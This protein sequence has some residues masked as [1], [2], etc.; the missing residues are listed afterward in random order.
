MAKAAGRESC[1]PEI[2]AIGWDRGFHARRP[3]RGQGR[4]SPSD[5]LSIYLR[6][7]P[8]YRVGG[9][10]YPFSPPAALLV[11]EGALD[12]DRQE[13]R[14][15]GVFMLF[16]GHG[17]LRRRR[18]GGEAWVSL[19]SR[20]IAV[21]CVK[22]LSADEADELIGLLREIDAVRDIGP[23]GHMRR[24]ALLLQALAVYCEAGR[25]TPSLTLH[26]D[27]ARLRELIEERAFEDATLAEIYGQLDLSAGHAE[28]LFKKALGATP[29]AY[30]TKL[31]LR[32]AREM[33]MSSQRNVSQVAQAVGFADPLYFSRVF[34]KTFGVT[35]SSLIRDFSNTR[36][37][38]D[39]HRFGK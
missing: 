5:V 24:A 14:L 21:P 28:T 9:T 19:G 26:R 10:M 2:L 22:Q 4:P 7:G 31:R 39:A 36:K 30:R 32:R 17:L 25:D 3:G 27:A 13:G 18:G 20:R 16:H 34:R 12:D 11:P 23:V 35:P 29:V 8:R 33:L 37:Q 6:G 1:I 15:D 38:H